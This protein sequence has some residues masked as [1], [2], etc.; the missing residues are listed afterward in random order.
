MELSSTNF[1]T[2]RRN[3]L[4]SPI[5]FIQTSANTHFVCYYFHPLPTS[6]LSSIKHFNI[7]WI[8]LAAFLHSCLGFTCIFCS[9]THCRPMLRQ[10]AVILW[11]DFPQ[12][13]FNVFKTPACCL[14]LR[15][16]L[17]PTSETLMTYPL[18]VVLVYQTLQLDLQNYRNMVSCS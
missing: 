12:S 4:D 2:K 3:N 14:T 9:G 7:D 10:W 11:N 15:N 6:P 17:L 8:N 5:P 18:K 16:T 1:L 13:G